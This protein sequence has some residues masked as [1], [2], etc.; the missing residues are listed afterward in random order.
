MASRP[1]GAPIK[2]RE[3]PALLQGSAT[4]I[5]DLSLPH[6]LHMEILRSPH[7]HARIQAIDTSAAERMPGV[8]RVITGRDLIGRMKPLP[9]VWI[10]GGVESHF[11]AH[12]QD[13]PG[14]G[15]PLQADRVRFIGDGVA[16]VV[17]DTRYQAQDAL[18][19][20]VVDYELLPVVVE[21]EDALRA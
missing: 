13:V 4:F 16:A 10:P 19:S 8:V 9:C 1:F 15:M 11:P 17:A 12:P 14:A 2:R 5:A 3:D 6:M 21:A 20:I 18:S 7:A